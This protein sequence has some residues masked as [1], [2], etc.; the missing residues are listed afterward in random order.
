FEPGELREATLDLAALLFAT[1]L[2]PDRS[3]VLVQSHV[4]A[5]PDA[6]WLLSSVTSFGELRRMTQFKDRAAEQDFVSAGLFT[7]P[8]LMAR[9]ILLSQN[10][11]VPVR[12]RHPALPDRSRPGRR[13]PATA[14]RADA[15]HRRA[16]QPAL[17]E[18]V[19]RPRGLD[20]R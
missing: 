3:T 18:D 12:R 20:P 11:L 2:D 8:V 13:R 14:R 1:G 6:A 10:D 4:T 19:R 17:R 9:D 5:H 7:Y 16:V 15:R